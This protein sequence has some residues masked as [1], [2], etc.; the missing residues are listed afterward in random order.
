MPGNCPSIRA[1]A[2]TDIRDDHAKTLPDLPIQNMIRR[3]AMRCDRDFKS[4]LF[5]NH[6]N[7]FADEIVIVDVQPRGV[8]GSHRASVPKMDGFRDGSRVAPAGSLHG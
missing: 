2:K 5:Q 8:I 7:K 1:D 3:R 4:G 6:G